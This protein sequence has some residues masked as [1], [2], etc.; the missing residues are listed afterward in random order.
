MINFCEIWQILAQNDQCRGEMGRFLR[1]FVTIWQIFQ[2]IFRKNQ[3][4]SSRQFIHPILRKSPHFSKG[5]HIACLN[6]HQ[7]L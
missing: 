5:Y 3:T 4:S 2:K 6:Y 7:F 1:C